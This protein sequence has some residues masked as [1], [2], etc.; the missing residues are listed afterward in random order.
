LT[1][2]SDRPARPDA[3]ADADPAPPRHAGDDDPEATRMIPPEALAAALAAAAGAARPQ[4]APTPPAADDGDPDATLVAD[5]PPPALVALGLVPAA[6]GAALAPPVAPPVLS[7]PPAAPAPHAEAAAPAPAARPA[8]AAV[9]DATPA[10]AQTDT[11]K[12]VATLPGAPAP[13]RPGVDPSGAPA[14][15]QVGRYRI[16]ERLGRGGMASVFR[17]H[18]PTIGRDV[19]LKFLHASLCEDDDYRSRFLHEARAAGGLS[20]P[21]IVIVHDVG[22][23][24]GRPYMAMELLEGE[25]LGKLMERGPLPVREVCEIGIQIARAL[26]FAHAHHIVHR[27]I[28]PGNI[29]RVTGSGTVKVLDFGIAHVESADADQRTRVGDVLG[30]PQYMSPEQTAGEKLD[31]RSDLFSVGIILYQLLT[32]QKPFVGDS[33][34]AL[35]WKIANTDP[36]PVESLRPDLPASMRRIVARSLQ[37]PKEM[38]FQ[39]GREL[40]EALKG[41]IAE[42]DEAARE[43][44][45]EKPSIIPLRVKWAVTM[46]FIV[47]VVMGITGA[48]ITQRQSAAMLEQATSSGASLARFIAA[49]NAVSALSEDWPGV[50]VAVQ[51]MMKTGDFQSIAVIDRAGVVRAAADPSRVDQPWHAPEGEAL[52]TRAGG[53]VGTRYLV[54]GEPVLGFEA[55]MTFAGKGVGRVALGLAE[56]PLVSVARLSIGLMMML[57]VVTVAAVGI[58]MYFVAN[59]FAQPIKL[60]SRAMGEVTRGHYDVRIDQARKDEYGLLYRAFDEMAQALEQRRGESRASSE[61]ATVITRAPVRE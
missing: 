7:T 43:K 50:N 29:V 39:T 31:G 33:L 16:L 52:G 41:V 2:D 26:D 53:V 17:A 24:D 45:Q 8:P 5:Q 58:A 54:A 37:K 10:A 28:K 3:G 18:D 57:V 40:V 20:H 34:V 36:P 60:L 30:T 59:W 51:E 49:Q 47:A 32:G 35:A 56:K 6:T 11:G 38:R 27:D 55:P 12:F 46:A 4:A 1:P 48:L 19:A 42:E 15:R 9:L 23:I 21:N 22:E 44:A 14:V 61:P 25:P 13:T